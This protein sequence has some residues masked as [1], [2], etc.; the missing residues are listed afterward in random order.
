MTKITTEDIRKLYKQGSLRDVDYYLAETLDRRFGGVSPDVLLAAAIVSHNIT[1]NHICFDLLEF[2]GK[3]WPEDDSDD[4]ELFTV[5]LPEKDAWIKSLLASPICSDADSPDAARSPLVWDGARLYLGRFF[6]YEK[7][8]ASKLLDLASRQDNEQSA[9]PDADIDHLLEILFPARKNNPDPIQRCAAKVIMNNRLL[10]LSGGPGTGKTYT[11]ARLIA[12][13]VAVGKMDEKVPAIRM[14]AP[15]GKAAMRMRKSIQDAKTD[16]T[17]SL[18]EIENISGMA[19]ILK[20]EIGNI[21]E[22][23]STIHRLLGTILNT[24]KFRHNADNP[25]PADIVI[26]DEASM[27]DISMM[28]KILDALQ[29]NTK[30]ILLGDMHQLASVDPGYVLGDICKAAQSNHTS[31]LGSSLVELKYSYRFGTDS[32]VGR[33]SAALHKAGGTDTDPDGSDAW[34]L[35]QELSKQ[36]NDER[37]VLWHQT[38]EKLC[39]KV[40]VPIDDFSS[41]ILENYKELLQST[42]VESAFKAM[43]EFRVFSPLRNG[44]HGLSTINRLIEKALSL[45]STKDGT[46]DLK[47]LNTSKEFYNHRVIMVTRNDYALNLFNGDIGIVLPDDADDGNAEPSG[48]KN[49][50]VWFESTN[51]E[52]GE[53]KYNPFPCNMIPEHETAFAM[54][55]HKSQGSQYTNV[56]VILPHQDNEDLFTKELL[57]TGITRAEKKVYLWCNEDVFKAT[58]IRQTECTSG[59]R[60]SLNKG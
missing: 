58:A 9:I 18:D 3:E 51:K 49:N 44:P 33:L 52:T 36:E 57:Y 39:D 30:L 34:K 28:V 15:T 17:K 11:F 48:K 1:N 26:I 7:T 23:A 4:K 45:K 37:G 10:I 5:T 24:S 19:K 20:D 29:S 41:T 50:V 59:L 31:E 40:E 38:P 2:A 27:I 25:L 12:L 13:L 56:M 46:A 53:V 35:L 22:D 60:E 6:N 54:T 42:T 43:S 21:P 32:P 47:R 16:I 55:I 14:A 8:L